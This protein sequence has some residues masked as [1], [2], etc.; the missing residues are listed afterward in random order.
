MASGKLG[1]SDLPAGGAGTILYTVPASTVA[2]VNIRIANRNPSST[3]VRVA[4]GTGASPATTDYL[5]YDI[6]VASNGILEDTGIVCSAGEKVWVYSDNA[7]VSVRV[8]G[9]EEEA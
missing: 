4:I 6:L 2:T 9:F 3:K 5:E 1:S 8:H 7:N